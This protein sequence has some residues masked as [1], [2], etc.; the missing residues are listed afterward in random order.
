[1]RKVC[2]DDCVNKFVVEGRIYKA[3][4]TNFDKLCKQ[5]GV[6]KSFDIS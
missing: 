3:G 2:D 6:T 4:R 1:M 5:A